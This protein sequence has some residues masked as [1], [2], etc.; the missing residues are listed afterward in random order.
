MRRVRECPDEPRLAKKLHL[1]GATA[2]PDSVRPHVF[3]RLPDD[4]LVSRAD[5]AI[6]MVAEYVEKALQFEQMAEAEKDAALKAEF[7][8]QAKAYRKLAAKRVLES[9]LASLAQASSGSPAIRCADQRP[10]VKGH[11]L[12]DR[13]RLDAT[14]SPNKPCHRD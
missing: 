5:D 8:G 9:P 1:G 7:L 13:T 10:S 6:K 14:P 11:R 4:H 3:R 12:S 2:R